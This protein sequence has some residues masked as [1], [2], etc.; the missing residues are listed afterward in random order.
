[1]LDNFEQV[2][3]AAPVVADLLAASPR[4]RVLVSTRAVLRVY[5]EKEFPVPP[6]ALPDLQ[7]LPPPEQQSQYEAVQLFIARAQ[8]VK[9]DFTITSENAP[10]V[11]EICHRLD[12]LPLAIELA[13]ARVRLLPPNTLLARLSNRLKLLTSGARNLPPRQQTLRG[14][15]SWSYDLLD[16]SEQILFRR[17]G[18]FVGGCTTLRDVAD[19][20]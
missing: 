19:H 6:L 4:L 7:Q 1:V 11:A 5:G 17:L 10:A 8:D 16:E 3:G 18:A 15:I 12:G 13:A 9:P 20:R 14:A 2:L